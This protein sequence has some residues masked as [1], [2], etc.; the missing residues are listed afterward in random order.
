M[1]RLSKQ[2][3]EWTEVIGISPSAIEEALT[4]LTD[5][6]LQI[7]I[8]DVNKTI[9]DDLQRDSQSG[10]FN[11]YYAAAETAGEKTIDLNGEKISVP[12]YRVTVNPPPNHQKLKLNVFN[13][14]DEGIPERPRLTTGVYTLWG[15]DRRGQFGVGLRN[16]QQRTAG[17][18]FAGTRL[19]STGFQGPSPM[20]I[21]MEPRRKKGP[22]IRRPPYRFFSKGP[23]R[24]VPARNLYERIMKSIK[25]DLKKQGIPDDGVTFS[26]G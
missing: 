7:V 6:A 12:N 9:T 3:R 2:V 8:D 22:K 20:P 10:S 25:R 26:G 16:Q 21:R 24:A 4:A 17:G 13:L 5:T 18:R 11:G 23:L 15:R 14:V 1:A 19:R